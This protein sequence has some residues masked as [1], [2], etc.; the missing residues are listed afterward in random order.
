MN[1]VPKQWRFFKHFRSSSQ[2]ALSKRAN[3]FFKFWVEFFAQLVKI[4]ENALVAQKWPKN[5]RKSVFQFGIH[6]CRQ[7]FV[8]LLKS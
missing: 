4:V 6:F 5:R 2:K 8:E 3:F 7:F 1:I